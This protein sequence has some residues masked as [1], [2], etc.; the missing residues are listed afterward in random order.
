MI[1]LPRHINKKILKVQFEN[2]FI[3]S[4]TRTN[5]ALETLFTPG[6]VCGSQQYIEL[7]PV[8]MVPEK[9]LFKWKCNSI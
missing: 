6:D 8:L 1:N 9:L 3:F 2:N 7:T 4:T 5:E